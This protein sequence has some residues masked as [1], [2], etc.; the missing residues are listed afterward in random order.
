MVVA[1]VFGSLAMN[2][3][4]P[5][6]RGIKSGSKYLRSPLLFIYLCIY[7]FL[8]PFSFLICFLIFGKR[9]L[10]LTKNN[11]QSQQQPRNCWWYEAKIG[12]N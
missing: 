8:N 4:D 10:R 12:R 2:S 5:N 1:W 3:M 6:H 11:L 9:K 7:L